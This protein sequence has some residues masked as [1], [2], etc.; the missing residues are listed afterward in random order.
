MRE[1]GFT[2]LREVGFT[3]LREVLPLLCVK[4]ASHIP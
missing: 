4:W 1:A 2:R 3:R